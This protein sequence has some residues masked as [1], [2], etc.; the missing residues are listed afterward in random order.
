MITSTLELI[1]PAV[2]ALHASA[3]GPAWSTLVLI[4]NMY[5][6]MRVRGGPI[7]MEALL[8]LAVGCC[9]ARA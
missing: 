9:M 7:K 8:V 3:P 2:R 6:V 1:L 5:V 4:S